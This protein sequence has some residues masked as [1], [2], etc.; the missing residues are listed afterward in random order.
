MAVPPDGQFW[1]KIVLC[2]PSDYAM[3][4]ECVM[5]AS[6]ATTD[7]CFWPDKSHKAAVEFI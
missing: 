4:A 2:T 7:P 3:A 1:S 5:R 6:Y